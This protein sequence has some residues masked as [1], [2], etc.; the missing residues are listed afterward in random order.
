ME[1]LRN[2]T[3]YADIEKKFNE[4]HDKYFVSFDAFNILCISNKF[5][6]IIFI[7]LR[8]PGFGYQKSKVIRTY[9]FLSENWIEFVWEKRVRQLYF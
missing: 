3:N 1:C 5:C 4:S 7:G 6:F 9:D 8:W 2:M